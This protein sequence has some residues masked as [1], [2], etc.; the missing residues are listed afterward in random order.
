[1]KVEDTSEVYPIS[2]GVSQRSVLGLV[3]HNIY[4]TDIPKQEKAELAMFAD[5]TLL[6]S[7]DNNA[8]E[9]VNKLR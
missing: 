2:A 9:A 6:I 5:D 8:D 1:M 7:S 3:F 4:M